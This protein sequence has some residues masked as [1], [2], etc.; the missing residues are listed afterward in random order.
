MSPFAAKWMDVKDI[1]LSEIRQKK[2][3]TIDITYIWNLKNTSNY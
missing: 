1:M 2:T 3:S